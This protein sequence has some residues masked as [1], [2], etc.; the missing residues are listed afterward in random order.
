M[1]DDS[2]A[3]ILVQMERKEVSG[4]K[5]DIAVQLHPELTNLTVVAALPQQGVSSMCRE[6]GAPSS[7]YACLGNAPLAGP[8]LIQASKHA[9]LLVQ[10]RR[11][12]VL[13]SLKQV[14]VD[15]ENRG[16]G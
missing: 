1:Y 13:S 9:A 5:A 2:P 11:F 12:S 8:C 10:H 14:L 6:S 15:H 16:P 7:S 3:G 4:L